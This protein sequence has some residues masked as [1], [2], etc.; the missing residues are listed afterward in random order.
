MPAPATF[1]VPVFALG[2]VLFPDGLL[3]LRVFEPRYR[4]MVR[5]CLDQERPFAVALIREGQ[6][7]GPAARCY[8]IGTLASIV[9]H[10]QRPDGMIYLTARGEERVQL[11]AT[12]VREDGLILADVLRLEAEPAT[13]V[14]GRHEHLTEMLRRA[15][16]DLDPDLEHSAQ[17]DDASWVG[18]RLAELLPIAPARRQFLLELTNPTLRLEALDE[19]LAALAQQGGTRPH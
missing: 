5:D 14:A 18:F 8:G 1:T 7:V 12:R 10:E 17:L 13:G 16:R 2:T 15:Y 4:T 9:D 3:P 11:V 19:A 6:E